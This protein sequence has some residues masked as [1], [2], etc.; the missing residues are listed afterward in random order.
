M[1]F[2]PAKRSAGSQGL[3]EKNT[4]FVTEWRKGR[5]FPKQPAGLDLDGQAERA[6]FASIFEFLKSPINQFFP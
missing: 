4:L 2:L 1:L 5:F 3:R 6:N